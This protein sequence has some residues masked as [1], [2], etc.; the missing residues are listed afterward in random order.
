MQ[1]INYPDKNARSK[2]SM[3]RFTREEYGRSDLLPSQL[4]T[5]KKRR[6]VCLLLLLAKAAEKQSAARRGATPLM[7]SGIKGS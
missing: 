4:T 2:V 5:T 6:D 3:D 1:N 7:K